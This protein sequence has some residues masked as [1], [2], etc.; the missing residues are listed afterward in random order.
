MVT[1]IDRAELLTL[2]ADGAQI[3]DVLPLA[4]YEAEHIPGA[5]SIP[6][7]RLTANASEVL[8]RDKPVV[9]Y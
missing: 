2:I 9:V 6:L 8:S 3:V 4:E 1:N 7:R 5:V